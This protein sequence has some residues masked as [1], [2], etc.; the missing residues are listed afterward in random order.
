MDNGPIILRS[1]INEQTGL[2]GKLDLKLLSA[3]V[4]KDTFIR[5]EIENNQKI[6]MRYK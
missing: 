3:K 5:T 6:N 2:D 1:R 4:K